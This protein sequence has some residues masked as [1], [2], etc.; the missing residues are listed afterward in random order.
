MT[1]TRVL[2]VGTSGGEYVVST[3]NDGPITPT[4]TLIR[5]YSNYGSAN[6]DPVQVADVTLFLQRG[7]RKVR[8]FRFVGDVDTSGYTAPDMTVLAEHITE[9]GITEFA[10]QQEPDSVV[11]AL[12]GDGVLPGLTYRREEQVVAWHKHTIGGAFSTGNAVVESIATLPTDTGEDELY[13][14]VKRTINSQNKSA[15]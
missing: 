6:A 1:A 10:Y 8:E 2:T 14:I 4:T 15:M 9:G 11:W 5:K 12:R 7:N 3:T 13:M